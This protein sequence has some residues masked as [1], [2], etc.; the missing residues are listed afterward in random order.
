MPTPSSVQI[1]AYRFDLAQNGHAVKDVD[2]GPTGEVSF[3]WNDWGDGL[4]PVEVGVNHVQGRSWYTSARG[5]DA[6]FPGQLVIQP[7]ATTVSVASGQP[8]LAA[9]FKQVDFAISGSINTYLVQAG[10]T[11][12]RL[13]AS[14]EWTSVVSL[15]GANAADAIVHGTLLGVAYASGYKHTSDGTTWTTVAST[16]ALTDRFGVLAENVWRAE[17]P[18]LLY[19]AL[20]LTGTW[21]SSYTV[22]DSS[23]SVNSITGLE[24]V[25]M[26][27]KEDGIYSIDNEGSVV[28]FTPELRSQADTNFASVSAATTFNGDFYFR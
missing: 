18:N 27:G 20:G 12:H 9:P 2:L 1:G 3:P 4:A 16:N 23:Y 21:S 13:N 7:Q 19:S 24:Q 5:V 10:T 6:A 22:G 14:T 25:L 8:A 28:Q 11:V 15:N 17:R 26:A